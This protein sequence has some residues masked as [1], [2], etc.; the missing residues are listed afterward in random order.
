[1]QQVYH[2]EFFNQH[3]DLVAD[4]DSWC[5]RTDRDH[6]REQGTKYTELKAE[7]GEPLH[8][9]GARRRL[10]A[11]RDEKIRG[12]D[13]AVLGRRPDGETL[14][15]MVKG[16]MTVTGFIAYAQGWGGLYIRA[17]KLAWKLSRRASGPRH[18][19]SLQ[20]SRLS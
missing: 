20:H 3:G 4:A 17:N 18:Q 15:T 11:L 13:A 12:A 9:R 14:P 5:F 10:P 16:P 19:E 1:M 8:R 7:A 6:A 2:V